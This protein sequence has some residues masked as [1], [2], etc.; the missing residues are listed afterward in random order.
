MKEITPF[1]YTLRFWI[2]VVW[3]VLMGLGIAALTEKGLGGGI[4][5]SIMGLGLIVVEIIQQYLKDVD[6][7][8]HG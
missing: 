3:A 4:Y 1:Y 2:R 5:I 6:R 8:L 7:N